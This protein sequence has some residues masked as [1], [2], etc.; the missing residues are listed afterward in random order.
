[1]VVCN[2]HTGRERLRFRNHRGA[3][4]CIAFS[5]DG[6]LAA[7]GG[8]R[9]DPTSGKKVAGGE[10]RVWQT[11]DGSEVRNRL[12]FP[13]PVTA[14]AFSLDGKHLASNGLKGGV[15]LWDLAN[16]KRAELEFDVVPVVVAFSPDGQ[17]LAAAGRNR[18]RIWAVA[19]GYARFTD[20]KGFQCPGPIEGLAYSPNG[21]R[22]ALACGGAKGQGGVILLNAVTGEEVFP[23]HEA[24]VPVKSV[25]YSPDGRSLAAAGDFPGHPVKVWDAGTGQERY[26]LASASDRIETVAFDSEG[27][28]LAL[29]HASR[30]EAWHL[31]AGYRPVRLPGF[32]GQ[33]SVTFSEDG[34]TVIVSGDEKAGQR[35]VMAWNVVT[36]RHEAAPSAQEWLPVS[37]TSPDGT[38]RFSFAADNSIRVSD[39]STEREVAALRGHTGPVLC[40][41]WSPDGRR[42]ASGGEGRVLRVW[43]VASGAELLSL[44]RHS[45]AIVGVAF[46][47]DGSFLASASEDGTVRLWD[48]R[49]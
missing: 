24:N 20:L 30:V 19:G 23:L 32:K 3:I 35:K 31:V 40:A 9:V 7:S 38:R 25:A 12:D 43:D 14:V 26:M 36:H 11:A 8:L 13:Q 18:V 22:L 17:H 2:A 49:P 45:G 44:R 27:L 10:L 16:G 42:L 37:A 39:T 6:R 47:P 41:A 4:R 15:A 34:Q 29:S 33:R 1:V 21:R 48:G 28:H 5:H 46:S